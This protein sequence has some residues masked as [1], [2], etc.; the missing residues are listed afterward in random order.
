MKIF[1]MKGSQTQTKTCVD[2]FDNTPDTRLLLNCR[3]LFL[4]RI[5]EPSNTENLW[6]T[7]AT[8]RPCLIILKQLCLFVKMQLLMPKIDRYHLE[9]PN[10]RISRTLSLLAISPRYIGLNQVWKVLSSLSQNNVTATIAWLKR[11]AL[12]NSK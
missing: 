7:L 8:I 1:Q 12:I 9:Y 5:S 3:S 6:C 10:A 11:D 2:R 4:E